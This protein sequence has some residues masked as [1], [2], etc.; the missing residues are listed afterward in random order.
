LSV[1]KAFA[2]PPADAGST[3]KVPVPE[4][5]VMPP[6]EPVPAEAEPCSPAPHRR[7]VIQ[8]PGVR[9]VI[10]TKQG[11]CA[12]SP[13]RL[14]V[15]V[16]EERHPFHL[17][18]SWDNGLIFSSTDQ[19]FHIHVGGNA[20]V[21]STW[22]I[23]PKSL[24]FLSNGS[25]N[26]V[27]N[28]SAT[29]L[30]R[31]RLRLDGDIYDQF[32]FM[33]EYDL[34]NADNE[35]NGLQPP[36]FGNLNG[37]PAPCNVW[38]QVRDVPFFGNV[39]IGNQVKPIGM[40]NNQYQGFLPFMERPDNMDAFYGPF[41]KGFSLGIT[42]RHWTESERLTWQYGIYRPATDPF[43]VA[44][45]K[46][47]IG[48]RATILPWYQDDGRRLMHLGMG[49]WSGEMVQNQLQV[50]ARP[51]L[52]NAPGFAEPLLV[53]TGDIP[54][55]RQYIFAPEFALVVGS[56]TLQAEWAGQV[57]TNALENGKNQG[58]VF[59]NG[60]Y[61]EVLYFLTGEHQEYD[62]HDGVFGRV[63]P[64]FDYH[65]RKEEEYCGTGAWQVGVRFSYLNANDGAIHGGDVYDWTV[66][67]NWFLNPNMKLQLNY[68]AEKVDGPNAQG[69]GWLNGVGVRAAYDF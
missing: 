26:G 52:R 51:L 27:E 11:E 16:A 34:A 14:P 46:Y 2:Q 44:L 37:S 49:Y 3:Q 47:D 1:D 24:F 42:S 21:D 36:S 31:A 29:L 13:D 59:Y 58:N 41:D 43:G 28:D 57:L 22:L 25:A 68:I 40:T 66:G 55:G 69:G 9:V 6:E 7:C 64:R 23:A 30:R 19:L 20:Q 4:T 63:I 38:M 61:I 39:R 32:D 54:A 33:F 8:G 12:V 67:L 45:N 56:F 18:A 5:V 65:I 62:R 35:N 50:R 17:D 53:N 60:G 15:P 10:E 48:G